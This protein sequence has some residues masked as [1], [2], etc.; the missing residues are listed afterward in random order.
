VSG[1]LRRGFR[2]ISRLSLVSCGD[3]WGGSHGGDLNVSIL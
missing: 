1:V 2:F 3:T